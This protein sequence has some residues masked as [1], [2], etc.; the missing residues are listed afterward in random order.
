MSIDQADLSS[1]DENQLMKNN[2]NTL[3]GY[4]SSLR[5]KIE[6]S[7]SIILLRKRVEI[8]ER[9]SIANQQYGRRQTI[10][11]SNI[12]EKVKACYLEETSVKILTKIGVNN[13]QSEDINACHRL[14]NGSTI[15]QF[16][17]RRF[18]D[19]ALHFRKKIGEIKNLD[20][21]D[22]G[23]EPLPTMYVNESM[24]W[25]YKFF[26]YKIRKAWRDKLIF[27][28]NFWKGKLTIKTAEHSRNK[29]ISHVNDL[30]ELNLATLEEYHEQYEK[31]MNR[32]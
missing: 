10:E 16:K 20:G 22:K 13:L 28:F 24:C 23:G 21:V 7:E 8:V 26:T 31:N 2:K 18:A 1:Q 30:I 19:E 11:I 17:S 27:G 14:K 15:I 5:L 12:P 29:V 4:I 25:A 9:D 32:L 6:E 3:I